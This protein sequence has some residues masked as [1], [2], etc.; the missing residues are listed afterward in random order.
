MT[1]A[2]SDA[3]LVAQVLQGRAA[4]FEAL[5]RRHLESTWAIAL[6]WTGDPDDAEDVCQD[7]FVSALERLPGLRDRERFAAWLAAI[8]RN[9]AR[10]VVRN[11]SAREALPLDAASAASL[12]DPARDAE[13]AGL[14]RDL[15]AALDGLTATQREVLLLH[16]VEGWR[17]GEIAVRTGLAEGT[18][19]YHLHRARRSLRRRLS[20]RYAEEV[21]R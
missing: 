16:D 21:V 11:R 10:N 18:I 15:D 1:M 3:Q 8:V 17:H 19:R 14:R 12:E 7:A 9:R 2:I 6:A 13:R 4:A 20:G 5:V